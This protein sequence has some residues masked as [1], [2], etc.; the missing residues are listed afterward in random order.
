MKSGLWVAFTITSFVMVACMLAGFVIG[1]EIMKDI[2]IQ[3]T[4]IIKVK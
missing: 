3:E 1:C 4:A 2:Q